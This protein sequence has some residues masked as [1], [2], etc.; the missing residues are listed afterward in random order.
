MTRAALQ[1]L[2]MCDGW[3]WHPQAHAWVALG[4][5]CLTDEAL[6]KKCVPL[7]VQE[8]GRAANPAVRTLAY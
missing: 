5:L 1:V 8:L 6:A 3:A 4:K 2:D 7:F